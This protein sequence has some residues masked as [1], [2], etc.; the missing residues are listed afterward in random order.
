MTFKIIIMK[1]IMFY[2]SIK[3][4]ELFETQKFYAIDIQLLRELGYTVVLTNKIWDFFKI[5]KYDISFIYFYRKGALAAFISRMF[6][7]KVYFTGGVDALQKSFIESQYAYI[8]QVLFFKIC[9]ALS[10]KCILV[11]SSDMK[12][13]TSLYNNQ[14]K[15]NYL[16]FHSI[17]VEKFKCSLCEKSAEIFLSIAWMESESNVIRKGLDKSLYIFS[18]LKK[19]K[20]KNAIFYIVGKEGSGSLYLSKII[21]ELK[22]E[23]SVIFTGVLNEYEKIKLLKKATYY[24]QLSTYEGFGIAA[25]EALAAYNIVIHSGNGG[26]VDAISSYGITYNISKYNDLKYL[27]NLSLTLQNFEL[28]TKSISTHLNKFTLDKRK[29]DFSIIIK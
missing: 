6:N 25:L 9:Y 21:K 19:H 5:N 18:Y 2:S 16:S 28:D 8:V 22:L 4:T 23:N 24:F 17:D 15:K 11:S 1:K 12:N 10:T 27:E 20:Y 13:I 3:K 7:K 26:L 14:L 29:H